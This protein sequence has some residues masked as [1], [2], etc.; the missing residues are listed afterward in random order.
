MGQVQAAGSR[1]TTFYH[2]K[3]LP[4]EWGTPLRPAPEALT[5][6][7]QKMLHNNNSRSGLLLSLPLMVDQL[8]FTRTRAD[9]I[10]VTCNQRLE[11]NPKWVAGTP[12]PGPGS[13]GFLHSGTPISVPPPVQSSLHPI[14]GFVSPG[15]Y[16]K[17]IDLWRKAIWRGYFQ[18]NYFKAVLP[19]HHILTFGI[20]S[21]IHRQG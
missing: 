17:E 19:V 11:S 12:G 5:L 20:F 15:I 3:Q 16:V 9:V 8:S 7:T 18:R 4:P 6:S 2:L 13:M 1:S 10:Q 14:I 21:I